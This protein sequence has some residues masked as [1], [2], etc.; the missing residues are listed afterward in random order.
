VV[1]IPKNSVDT[2]KQWKAIE[3]GGRDDSPLVEVVAAQEH[4]I[5]L[6]STELLQRCYS[7]GSTW[8][9]TADMEIGKEGQAEAGEWSV[10][11]RETDTDDAKL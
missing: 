8:A 2:W 7:E 5:G 1:V 11:T 9:W 6:P 4:D 3:D 10:D